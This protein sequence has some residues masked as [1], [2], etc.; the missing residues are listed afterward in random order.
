MAANARC[1]YCG[2]EY[3]AGTSDTA[4]VLRRHLRTECPAVPE[5]IRQEYGRSCAFGNCD[6]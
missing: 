6:G 1:H 4:D 2:S 5:V 3:A